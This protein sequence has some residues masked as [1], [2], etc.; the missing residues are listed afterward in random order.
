MAELDLMVVDNYQCAKALDRFHKNVFTPLNKRIKKNEE[1]IIGLSPENKT[2]MQPQI[3][4]LHIQRDK[5]EEFEVS[6]MVLIK[7]HENLT[8]HLSKYFY[9]MREKVVWEG[10]VPKELMTE[11]QE[12]LQ[13]MYDFLEKSLK[14]LDL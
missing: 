4:A 7:R 14:E 12:I 9:Q 5:L 10:E 2:K 11:Q 1:H 8:T 3:D 6:V 13:N